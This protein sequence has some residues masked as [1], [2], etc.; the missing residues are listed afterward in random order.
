MSD[1]DL[2]RGYIHQENF[3]DFKAAYE[4]AVEEGKE[5]FFFEE[6]EVLTNYAKY[7]VQYVDAKLNDDEVN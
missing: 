1:E 6:Q 5:I 3:E 4:K 2:I 7:V